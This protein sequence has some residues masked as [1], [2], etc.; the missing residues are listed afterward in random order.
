MM[1]K[2]LALWPPIMYTLPKCVG[3]YTSLF[4]AFEY[5]HRE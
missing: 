1:W 4:Q 5:A 2:V 3:S